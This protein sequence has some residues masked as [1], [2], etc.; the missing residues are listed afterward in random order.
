MDTDGDGGLA[1][2]ELAAWIHT[3]HKDHIRRDV[4]REWKIR[5]PDQVQKLSWAQYRRNV[6]GGLQDNTRA[7]DTASVRDLVARE[8]RR[9]QQADMDGDLALNILEFQSF[10]HPESDERM[11]EVVLTEIIEDMDLDRDGEVSLEEYLADTLEEEEDA[12]VRASERD[13]FS[14]QLDQDGDGR[15]SRAEVRTWLMPLQHD[16]A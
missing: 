15:L 3:V 11:A 12:E 1:V 14:Q 4:E 7:L 5:N 8:E 13:N 10:L 16:Y 2:E 9:W 6:Y